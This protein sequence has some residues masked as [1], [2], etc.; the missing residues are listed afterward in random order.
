MCPATNP[1]PST[2]QTNHSRHRRRGER[3]PYPGPAVG[4]PRRV[5]ASA[6]DPAIHLGV[7]GLGAGRNVVGGDHAVPCRTT[8]PAPSR[9]R[10][11]ARSGGGRNPQGRPAVWPAAG[12]EAGGCLVAVAHI[13]KVPPPP[14]QKSGEGASPQSGD[15]RH[16]LRKRLGDHCLAFTS[17]FLRAEVALSAFGRVTVSRPLSKIASTRSSTMFSG[18]RNERTKL[19]KLR[20]LR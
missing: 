14:F 10:Q 5:G 19:P 1:V 15:E 7:A 2:R 9:P 20:S 6:S 13:P 3:R 8:A 11:G 16:A 12:G 17:I 4:R 18:R